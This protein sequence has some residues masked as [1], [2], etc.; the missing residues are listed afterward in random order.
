MYFRCIQV[1][2]ILKVLQCSINAAFLKVWGRDVRGGSH[3]CKNLSYTHVKRSH[4]HTTALQ[5]GRKAMWSGISPL[6]NLLS[7]TVPPLDPSH[8]FFFQDN[9]S[10]LL[11]IYETINV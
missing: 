1:F 3:I 4:T 7:T 11:N 5:S 9:V 10:G 2:L 8:R 6:L